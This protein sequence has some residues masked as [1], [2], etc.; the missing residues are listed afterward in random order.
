MS[1]SAAAAGSN[2]TAVN[3]TAQELVCSGKIE[4]RLIQYLKDQSRLIIWKKCSTKYNE[5]MKQYHILPLTSGE[6]DG[7]VA[8]ISYWTRIT[9]TTVEGGNTPQQVSYE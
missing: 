6:S 2:D 5:L 4:I 7:C 3:S 1:T 8:T 9:D